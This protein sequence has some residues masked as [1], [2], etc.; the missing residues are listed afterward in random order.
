M[1]YFIEILKYIGPFIGV[2]IGWLLAR[3][4]ETDKIRYDELRHIKKSLYL[5][6]E[7]RNQLVLNARIN[8]YIDTL[9]KQINLLIES[10]GSETLDP[11]MIN[12]LVKKLIPSLI[13]PN[14]QKDIKKQFKKSIERL[15]EINPTLAYRINGKQNIQDYIENWKD[16]FNK[17]FVI[18][19]IEDAK[20]T[21][22]IIEPKLTN[23]IKNDVEE[24]IKKVA[25]QIGKKELKIVE[26]III[27]PDDEEITKNVEDYLNK[28]LKNLKEESSTSP[29]SKE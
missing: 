1:N 8:R 28:M 24:I 27:E 23:E 12:E 15:S 5:L 26:N 25:S 7:I 17:Y 14:Y 2:F 20:K 21:V 22:E 13:G 4:N 29:L 3:K 18:N 10:E 11:K 6:L 16:Q 19:N 9:T